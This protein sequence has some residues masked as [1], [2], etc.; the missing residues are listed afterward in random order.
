MPLFLMTW[1]IF[2]GARDDCSTM[3][4]SMNAE[5]DA[6]DAGACKLLGRFC[7]MGAARGWAV[8]E[9]PTS[10]DINAWAYSWSTMANL[11]VT[12]IL[13][14]DMAREVILKKK[15]AFNAK[16]N[17]DMKYEPTT[18]ESIYIIKY[19][20]KAGKEQDGHAAFA[21]MTE[22]ADKADPGPCKPIGRY[23]NLLKANGIGICAAKTEIDLYK[24]GYNWAPL[25]D[26][27]VIPVVTDTQCRKIVT[28]K[29]DHEKKLKALM[30]KMSA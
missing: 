23:H 14:D 28:A 27:E 25:C 19:Q 3:F 13:D 8:A 21:N 2:D 30:A 24:W 11:I 15:P 18:G 22:E 20:F 29:P 7:D 10:S 16:Y 6:K 4:G 9:A 1:K 12:P 5:A 17:Y 26:I